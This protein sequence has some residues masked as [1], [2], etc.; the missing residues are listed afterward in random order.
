MHKVSLLET[1]G[2]K[3]RY[4]TLSHCWGSSQVLTTTEATLNERLSCIRWQQLPLLFQDAISLTR[5]LGLKYLWIN[6]LCILQGSR[7]DWEKESANMATIYANSYLNIAASLSSGS[8]RG[9]FTQRWTTPL[10]YNSDFETLPKRPV[11]S[12]VITD[13]YKQANIRGR[14]SMSFAHEHIKLLMEGSSFYYSDVPQK[15]PLISRGWVYQERLLSPRTVHFH[16]SELIW[17]CKETF[18]CE[19]GELYLGDPFEYNGFPCISK[20]WFNKMETSQ[21][22]TE[23]MESWMHVVQQYSR[24]KLSHS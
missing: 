19:C 24:L 2:K 18:D 9:L 17:E 20:L 21:S 8:R 6:S 14:Y 5:S 10:S 11:K 3:G 13:C 12:F 22:K 16:T 7:H 4:V 23:I 1:A 15:T